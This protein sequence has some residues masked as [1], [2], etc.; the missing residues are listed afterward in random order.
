MTLIDKIKTTSLALL[1]ATMLTPQIQAS[2]NSYQKYELNPEQAQQ[3]RNLEKTYQTLEKSVLAI[4]GEVKAI[5]R[6]HQAYQSED[7]FVKMQ[8][9]IFK[10]PKSFLETMP[11]PAQKTIR[12]Y[13]PSNLTPEQIKRYNKE[14]FWSI[15]PE[16]ITERDRIAIGTI[17]YL[18][19]I[20]TKFN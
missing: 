15:N 6:I 1:T 19:N 7:P 20:R 10:D 3:M 2:E 17:N 9:K 13:D 11:E 14:L 18:T 4:T 5:W 8:V 16:K 12:E